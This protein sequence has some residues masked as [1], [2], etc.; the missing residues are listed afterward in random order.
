MSTLNTERTPQSREGWVIKEQEGHLSP[1]GFM[2]GHVVAHLQSKRAYNV[3]NVAD[4]SEDAELGGWQV[5]SE[6][7][8]R[9]IDLPSYQGCGCG[10][11]ITTYGCA[12][13]TPLLD[14]WYRRDNGY[15]KPLAVYTITKD[16]V[17]QTA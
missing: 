14:L 1:N 15:P 7:R 10:G 13:E 16:G 12:H 8:A 9:I 6:F 17:T 11:V 2:L 3:R 5:W 4:R